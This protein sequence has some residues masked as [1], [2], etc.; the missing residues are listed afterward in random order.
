M[1]QARCTT[2][3]QP[4]KAGSSASTL[5]SAAAHVTLGTTVSGMR[6]AM[7]T[8]AVDGRVGRE[9]VDHR[10][11]DVP[12]CSDDGDAH[13]GRYVHWPAGGNARRSCTARE[14]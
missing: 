9:G 6:R 11:P 8:M 3:A 12:G 2:A 7:P 10:R 4:S 13:G 1:R 5:T 14:G